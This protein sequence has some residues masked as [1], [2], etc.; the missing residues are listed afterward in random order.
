MAAPG[1]TIYLPGGSYMHITL[2]FFVNFGK[3]MLIL[4]SRRLILKMER[5]MMFLRKN[6]E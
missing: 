2:E 3:K 4:F 1:Q 5:K 6:V